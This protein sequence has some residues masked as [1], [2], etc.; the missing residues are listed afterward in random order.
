MNSAPVS[1]TLCPSLD[2]GGDI[3]YSGTMN[4]RLVCCLA[5]SV[6]VLCLARPAGA[7]PKPADSAVG[8]GPGPSSQPT[9]SPTSTPGETDP[10]KA[11]FKKPQAAQIDA[12][13]RGEALSI[14]LITIGPGVHPFF[15][16]G[17]NTIWVHDELESAKNKDLA[18]NF[19]AFDSTEPGL[20]GKFFLGRMKYRVW[21]R[22]LYKELKVY[23]KEKRWMIAQKL[24][25]A[26]AKRWE[27]SE[28]LKWHVREENRHYLYHYFRDN[29]STRVR[30]VLDKYLDGRLRK[31]GSGP[32]EFSYRQQVQRLTASLFPEYFMLYFVVSHMG[33]KPITMWDETF[34]PMVLLKLVSKTT[35]LTPQG[36]QPLVLEV[37]DLAKPILPPPLDK[38]P[39][40][41]FYFLLTGTLIGG[42][43]AAL[44]RLGR[45]R[46]WA[47]VI[48][49]ILLSLLGLVVGAL[50]MLLVWL[51]ILTDHDAMWANENIFQCPP[52]L[53]VLPVFVVGIAR[54]RPKTLRR[55]R[56]LALAA[57]G[58]AVL[59]VLLKA[60]PWFYQSNW[61]IIAAT[62]PLLAGI[63]LAAVW[64]GPPPS[65]V[66]DGSSA[67]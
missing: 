32:A 10:P 61:Q 15:K 44:G 50:G 37:L 45:A 59:G 56:W 8:A 19:G 35:V 2:H 65:R 13:K 5:L 18:Y 40:W 43:V 47:R 20:V 31:A 60:L 62:V 33:D 9:A 12:A 17:H 53:I 26:P 57:A 63:A 41:F 64:L 3:K 67:K 58:A 27:L 36:E 48:T 6:T 22:Q 16:F 51:W 1:T 52:W 11:T 46:R 38:P 21:C 25:M 23:R 24:N 7:Q 28:Y 4:Q 54:G 42:A 30:D 55:V 29:C 14:F 39:S 34:I 49:A 66:G